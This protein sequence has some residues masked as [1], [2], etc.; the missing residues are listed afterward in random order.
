MK[1][2]IVPLLVILTA[3]YLLIYLFFGYEK[4]MEFIEIKNKL[5]ISEFSEHCPSPSL[6]YW[7]GFFNFLFGR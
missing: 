1:K 4:H 5:C 7:K 6:D 3:A 2:W